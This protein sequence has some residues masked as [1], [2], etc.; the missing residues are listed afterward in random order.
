MTTPQCRH[1]AGG[2][3]SPALIEKRPLE[4]YVA[5]S[6]PSL[7]GLSR[8]ALAEALGEARRAQA[9]SV[10]CVYSDLALARRRGVLDFDANDHVSRELRTQLAEHF[11]LARPEIVRINFRDGTRQWLLCSFRANS[12]IGRTRSNASIFR[13][14]GAARFVFPARSAARSTAPSASRPG[15]A[16]RDL[17]PGEIAGQVV[18]ARD[19]LD[20][21]QRAAAPSGADPEKRLVSN[22]VMMG[23]GEPLYNFEAVRDALDVVADGELS[24]S[25]RRRPFP[26]LASSPTSS[27]PVRESARCWRFRCTP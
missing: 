26:R 17:T 13:K 10:A 22:V 25:K 7:V 12:P 9:R 11:T 24:I 20:D 5:P 6:K 21:W 3:A 2:V 23:M 19:R 1:P 16:V 14:P 27:A 4:R 18:L 15:T 8:D